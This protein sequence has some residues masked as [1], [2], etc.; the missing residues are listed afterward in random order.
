LRV[1]DIRRPAHPV[2]VAYYN[3]PGAATAPYRTVS[4][5]AFAPERGEIWYTDG[6]YGFFA[7][8]VTN[9]AWLGN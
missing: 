6:N 7:L 8:E 9:D 4:A 2:E 1:F 5:P 3:P